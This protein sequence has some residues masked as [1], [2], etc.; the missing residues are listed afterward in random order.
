MF[1]NLYMTFRRAFTIVELLVV[2]VVVGL[3][4]AIVIVSYTGISQ[5]AA[6]SSIQTDLVNFSKSIETSR[7]TSAGDVYP[8]TKVLAGLKESNNANLTYHYVPGS[9]HICLEETLS[10]VTYSISSIKQTVSQS[11]CIYNDI[12]GWWKFNGDATDSS[13]FGNNG[14]VS[15][16]TLV[17]GQNGLAN[18]AYQ[19]GET[20]MYISV[21]SGVGTPVT[22]ATIGTG[23]FTYSLWVKRTGTS[24]N[25]WP[26]VMSS[27][28]THRYFGIRTYNYS[29][30]IGLETGNP[31]YAGASWNTIAVQFLT[32]N[33]WYHFAA[34]YDGFAVRSFVNGALVNTSYPP[35]LNPTFGG[36]IFS[37]ST[38]GWVGQVDD[39][40]IY[41]RALSTSE[42]NL[43]YQKNAE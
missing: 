41:N 36:L 25:Q 9:K 15:G 5:R 31:P 26:I 17:T 10:G 21:G 2:I 35:P 13:G 6:T 4:A 20:G 43:I 8:N 28:D 1:Y 11:Q 34:S 23:G 18:G 33:Q 38:Q 30:N 19:L 14:T 7:T 24:I 32:L 27:G 12:I 3:I 29:D 42:I 22:F 39:A 16:A 37:N 40:R